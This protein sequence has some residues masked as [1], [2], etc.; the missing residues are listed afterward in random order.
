MVFHHQLVAQ[1]ER[2]HVD[3]YFLSQN[4]GKMNPIFTND[5]L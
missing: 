4:V 3:V 2:F 1:G 5:V